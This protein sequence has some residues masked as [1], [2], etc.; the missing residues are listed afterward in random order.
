M[1]WKTNFEESKK[2]YIDWWNGKGLIISMWE[3]LEKDGEPHEIVPKP[4]PAKDLNQFWFDPVWRAQNIHYQLSRSSFKADILPVANT[5]LGPG[6]LAACLGAELNGGDDTI[7]IKHT[8]DFNDQI[9]FDST[10]KWWKMH[11]DLIKECKKLSKG[12]YRLHRS[13][14]PGT[15]D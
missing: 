11:L 10:N 4:Q 5:H 13:F 8:G 12:K 9:I 7:W 2:R 14:L 6:S 1:T 3:H 15:A